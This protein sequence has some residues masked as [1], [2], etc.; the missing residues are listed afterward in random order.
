MSAEPADIERLRLVLSAID[1]RVTRIERLSRGTTGKT[2]R[3]DLPGRRCVAKLFAPEAH[4]LLSA[5]EQY[6]LLEALAVHGISPQPVAYDDDAGVLVTEFIPDASA[7]TGDRLVEPERIDAVARSLR[8]LH[9]AAA[10]IRHFDPLA[11]A[12]RYATKLGGPAALPVRERQLYD[13]LIDAAQRFDCSEPSVCHND[14]V[15]DNILFGDRVIL[16][17]FDYA[18]SGPPILDLASFVEMNRLS[19]TNTG[20]LLDSYGEGTMPYPAREFA[21]VRRLVRLLAHFWSLASATP[22]ARAYSQ[23]RIDDV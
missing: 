10:D 13:E 18:A 3:F 2:Y 7:V 15:A 20:R 6:R 12:E 22:D 4:V 23:Y 5:G 21:R 11:A 14:L 19:E 16:I 9:A 17:D 1:G 8:S